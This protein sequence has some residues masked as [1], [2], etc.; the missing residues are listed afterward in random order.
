MGQYIDRL[1]GL[2][3]RGDRFDQGTPVAGDA[4][5]DGDVFFGAKASSG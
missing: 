3:L 2:F 5:V 4:L 1:A